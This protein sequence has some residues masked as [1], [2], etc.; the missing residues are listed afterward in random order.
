MGSIREAFGGLRGKMLVMSVGPVMLCV[1]FFIYTYGQMSAS[2]AN[3]EFLTGEVFGAA[4]ESYQV[5]GGVG[6]V[7]R[8]TQQSMTVGDPDK[9]NPVLA[10]ARKTG[11]SVSASVERLPEY[12]LTADYEAKAMQ[13]REA[14]RA[15]DVVVASVLTK[16]EK[17][18]MLATDEAQEE[19]EN[20]IPPV[21][22]KLESALAEMAACRDNVVAASKQKVDQATR[23]V[24]RT[25]VVGGAGSALAAFV[26][27]WVV[28]N[29]LVSRVKGLL[30][31]MVRVREQNDLT[32]TVPVTGNDEISKLSVA[33]G[34][35][36]QTLRSV[37][38]SVLSSSS[39]VAAAATETAASAEEVSR[40]MSDVAEQAG[41]LSNLAVESGRLA[42]EGGSS[43]QRT[44]NAMERIRDS[45]SGTAKNVGELGARG[46][47][48]GAIVEIIED[49][50]SQT[51]LLALN[52]AIEAAR[53][54]EMG[55]G[56]A[57][58]ADEVRKL[59]ERTTK[60][61]EE[62]TAQITAIRSETETVVRTMGDG[63]KLVEEGAGLAAESGSH[64]SSLVGSAAQVAE[65]VRSISTATDEVQS[66]MRQSA[67]ASEQ[68]STK[69]EQLAG[70]VSR[71]RV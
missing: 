41:E 20:R 30:G 70:F 58:V 7:L 44:V 48:I 34:E 9:R 18:T 31:V 69:A 37:I 62:V 22:E 42:T 56:F 6:N 19:C 5:E 13:V 43:T 67:E 27:A 21:S 11:K 35:L 45:V 33:V 17:N 32:V 47:Q 26:I 55:R 46:R 4:T 1:A 12:K 53:A 59:A 16:L 64:L 29:R 51:N 2:K 40:S 8:L 3:V 36:M 23:S 39:E 38:Q 71:F 50:A 66:S 28:S 52:A 14:Y 15:L 54:G 57:V 24:Q 49:I 10:A 25:L 65:R 63:T 61:T 60:A 68:L